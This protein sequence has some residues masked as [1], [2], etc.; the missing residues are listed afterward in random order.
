MLS[1]PEY[2][3]CTACTREHCDGR[4]PA[5][6]EI[7]LVLL[8]KLSIGPVFRCDFTVAVVSPCMSR[9]CILYNYVDCAELYF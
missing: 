1:S 2:G 3:D 5:A 7:E 9:R 8:R 6:A 4:Q